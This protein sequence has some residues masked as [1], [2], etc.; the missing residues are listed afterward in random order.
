MTTSSIPSVIEQQT[1]WARSQG[2]EPKNAYLL[3]LADNLLQQLSDG[4]QKDFERGNG[5]ELRERGIRPPKMH[6]LRSSSAL[7]ANVFDYWRAHDPTPLQQALGLRDKITGISFEEHFPT[8]LKGNPPNVG[9]LLK[10]EGNKYVAIET[11]FTQWLSRRERTIDPKYF[12][13][14][15]ELWSLQNLPN[16]QALA[17]GLL[18]AA[19]FKYLDV[20]L[21]LKHALGLARMKTGA[22]ELFYIYFDWKCPEGAIHADEVARFGDLVGK[23]I[24]FRTMTYQALFKRLDHTARPDNAAYLEYFHGRYQQPADRPLS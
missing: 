22:Y 21:L 9:V 10:L 2:F 7:S 23:E 11:K 3:S 8:G 20:P 13:P 14:G 5:G 1:R 18:E 6:A 4:A 15:E 17:I 19:P 24:G 12:P 16:C